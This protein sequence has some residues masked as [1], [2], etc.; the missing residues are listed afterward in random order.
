V[1]GLDMATSVSI[2][3]NESQAPTITTVNGGEYTLHSMVYARYR[4]EDQPYGAG[5]ASCTGTVANGAR[6]DTDTL[7]EHEYFVTAVDRAGNRATQR[8]HYRVVADASPP[9]VAIAAPVT[10]GRYAKTADVR[11]SFSCTDSGIES[12]SGTVASGASIDTA[13]LGAHAFTVTARDRNG[14]TATRTI[15]YTVVS[16]QVRPTISIAAPT[17]SGRYGQGARVAARFA[18]SDEAGGSGISTCIGTVAD[19]TAL[20]T[21]TRGTHT[22]TVTA[23]D[24][25]GNA[26][27]A[28][29]SYTVVADTTPPVITIAAPQTGT[30]TPRGPSLFASFY[31]IDDAGGLL[32]NCAAT[33]DGLPVLQNALSGQ[34]D[35]AVLARGEHTFRVEGVDPAG[36]RGAAETVFTVQ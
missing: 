9:T 30:V 3:V 36:N 11:A 13:T 32:E 35:T 34:I 22:F 28:Q 15:N 25:T 19:G 5:I 8:V 10:G 6:L 18:C 16:D 26:R 2:G 20:D 17:A 14:N 7:G 23:R 4:C 24:R 1:N 27:T 31:C 12:C 33:V 29:V 21:R